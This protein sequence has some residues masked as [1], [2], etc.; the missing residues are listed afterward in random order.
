METLSSSF[1]AD[2]FQSRLVMPNPRKHAADDV[3]V[4]KARAAA[5]AQA[6]ATATAQARAA[7]TALARAV[8]AAQA[9]AAA[10]AQD[11]ASGAAQDRDA[12]N[13][14]YCPTCRCR[15]FRGGPCRRRDTTPAQP[16]A[17]SHGSAVATQ[18]STPSRG[19]A[20]TTQLPAPSRGGATPNPYARYLSFYVY[21]LTGRK[22]VDRHLVYRLHS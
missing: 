1:M 6:R 15:A 7:A 10:A 14:C 12:A 11:R 22:G 4:E 20:V 16:S 8:A 5:A 3:A 21:L 18:L 13:L 17:P 9:R 2:W 19:S